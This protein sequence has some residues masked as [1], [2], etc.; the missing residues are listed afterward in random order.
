M[1]S[2]A[3]LLADR[4]WARASAICGLAAIVSYALL[5]GLPG[6]AAL[7][8]LLTLGFG[9]GLTIASIGLYFSVAAPASPRVG[10]VAAVSNTVAAG[11]LVAMILVQLAIGSTGDAA[12]PAL[13]AVS[14]ALDVGWDLYVAAGTFLF[15][16]A[17]RRAPGFGPLFAW[18]GMAVAAG[19]LVLNVATF[20]VPP[21]DAG[22]VDLGPAVA[23]W[24]VAVSIQLARLLRRAG[25]PSS[26]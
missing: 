19:L 20:P 5:I 26:A 6:P 8:A 17:M 10:L 18:S 4:T 12:G 3:P 25:P 16:L 15:A 7:Q 22:L 9:L 14:L 24:Y 21:G 23:L 1:E 13:R 2:A 11:L